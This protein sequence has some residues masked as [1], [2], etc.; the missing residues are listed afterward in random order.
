MFAV[1]PVVCIYLFSLPL[2]SG[3]RLDWCYLYS[4]RWPSRW[5]SAH[6]LVDLYTSIHSAF[7]CHHER[8]VIKFWPAYKSTTRLCCLWVNF[9]TNVK[10]YS[11]WTL[12]VGFRVERLRMLV[13]SWLLVL[14]TKRSR[15]GTLVLDCVSSL[16]YV[17]L[18][19]VSWALSNMKSNNNVGCVLEI[20]CFSAG[21]G[22]LTYFYA[23]LRVTTVK[24][25]GLTWD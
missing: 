7:R 10:L 1:C 9:L 25:C 6:I 24:K 2:L 20:L 16:W 14:V 13:H 11:K 23:I 4:A 17:Q 12:Y 5:A 21:I 15:S 18:C 22:H 8:V 3:R 19:S